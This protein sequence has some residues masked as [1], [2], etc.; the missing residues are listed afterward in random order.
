MFYLLSVD[1]YHIGTDLAISIQFPSK[2][3]GWGGIEILEARL[4]FHPEM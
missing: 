3:G 4:T 1:V 2:V